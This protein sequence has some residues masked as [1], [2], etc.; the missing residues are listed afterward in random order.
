MINYFIDFENYFTDDIAWNDSSYI[1]AYLSMED[2]KF[3]L[4]TFD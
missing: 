4:E 2:N 3:D 1:S